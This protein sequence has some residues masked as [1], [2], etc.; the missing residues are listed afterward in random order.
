LR[1]ATFLISRKKFFQPTLASRCRI[2]TFVSSML[3]SDF[4]CPSFDPM[5]QIQMHSLGECCCS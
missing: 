3:F 1:G 2:C 4:R 5:S